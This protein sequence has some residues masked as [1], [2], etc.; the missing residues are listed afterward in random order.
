MTWRRR[1]WDLTTLPRLRNCGRVSHTGV[2][3]AVVRV[4]ETDEG[5]RA[6]L[7]G[8][9]SCG[10]PW[11]CPVCARKIGAQRSEDVAAV[12]R[13]VAAAGGSA[14][15]VTLTMRHHKGHRLSDLWDALTKAWAAVTAGA[16]WSKDQALFGVL[17]FCKAVEVTNGEAGWHVHCHAVV[18]LDGPVS[19]ELMEELGGRMFTRWERKLARLGFSAVADKGGLDVRPVRMTA[20]S[21][22]QVADYISKI[23]S[24]ITSPTAKEAR[25]GNRTPFAILRD[26]LAT[27]NA[28][29]WDLWETW[30]RASHNRRQLTWSR[31]LRDWAGL[32]REKTDEEVASEDRGGEA[33]IIIPKESWPLVRDDVADL[34]DAIELGG[35]DQAVRWLTSRSLGFRLVTQIV[36]YGHACVLVDT[37]AA[38]ILL[39][40]GAFSS[41]FEGLTGLDAILVTHQHFDHVVPE[42]LDDLRRGNP[43][44]RLIVDSQTAEQLSVDAETVTPGETLTVAGA[45]V[46]VLGGDHAVIHPDI[47]VVR[48]NAYLIDGSLLHPGD[49]YTPVDRP[50]DTL[51]LPTGAPWLKVS[52]AVD[53]LRAV[54]PRQAVPIHEAVLANPALHYGMFEALAPAGTAVTVAP[55]AEALDLK[56]T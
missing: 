10:S 44:A 5:R 27:G 33:A 56:S 30:E 23:T 2:G 47:P 17:G 55:R 21:I 26:F 20:D 11:S 9:Q 43:S 6:G 14:A 16:S 34:L 53:Y 7:S 8:L 3:G 19:P 29:D 24:E 18:A 13:A 31:R 22:E 52:E 12:L 25:S 50:V 46:E 35:V 36:H 51:L 32:H 4:S 48:N 45:T 40:P 37:G 1:L 42:R 49:S 39:D 38:R 41:D 54:A 28:D 15:L